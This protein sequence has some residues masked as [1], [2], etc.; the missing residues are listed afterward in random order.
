[1][2][3]HCNAL[4]AE[5]L[6]GMVAAQRLRDA[7]FART[8]V[9]AHETHGGPVVMITGTGHV[10]RSQGVPAA[11]VQAA[12]SLRVAA[13]GAFEGPISNAP[14]FDY[15]ITADPTPR[16]DPCAGFEKAG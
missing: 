13:V 8:I 1:M 2:A 6:P 12:P 3:S 10:D 4:P 16:E 5:M 9:A 11:L 14:G 15:W 7:A